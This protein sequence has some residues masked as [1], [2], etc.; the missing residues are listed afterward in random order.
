MTRPGGDIAS[1]G[2][3]SNEI[4]FVWRTYP[5]ILTEDLSW[6]L[7][8]NINWIDELQQTNTTGVDQILSTTD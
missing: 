5:L 8:G 7:R 6:T 3:E 1:L 2:I 4:R